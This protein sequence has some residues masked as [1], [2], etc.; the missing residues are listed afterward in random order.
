MA[1]AYA[2]ITLAL[3]IAVAVLIAWSDRHPDRAIWPPRQ[4]GFRAR[5]TTWTVTVAAI[6]AAYLAGRAG[7]N[8]W[9]W[10]DFVR[11]Y[12]GFPL[13]FVSSSVSSWA[14]VRLGL[15]QS[16]GADNG[17]VTK[18][19]FARTR[20]PTYLANVALCLGWVLLAA[21]WPALIAAAALA[22]LYAFAVPFEERWLARTYGAAYEQYRANTPRWL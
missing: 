14:I 15:D 8:A 11:W 16:M 12:V 10:P 9:N 5:I 6:G 17:L 4:F 21:S 18:S 20:N 7:W 1:Y 22:A 2:L 19:P 13:T 3:C